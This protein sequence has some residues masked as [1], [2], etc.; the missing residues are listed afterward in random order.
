MSQEQHSAWKPFADFIND[1]LF[2]R[3]PDDTLLTA[4]SALMES[5]LT[6]GNLRA[7]NDALSFNPIDKAKF[8]AI[9]SKHIPQDMID[10]IWQDIE[11]G[12]L[13]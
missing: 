5:Q 8:Y 2:P 13:T 10:A 3:I 4:G 1:P 9:L 11:E 6:F 7:L 12:C